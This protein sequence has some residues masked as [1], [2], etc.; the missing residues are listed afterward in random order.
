[1]DFYGPCLLRMDPVD[2][3][4]YYMTWYAFKLRKKL[5]GLATSLKKRRLLERELSFL[6]GVL[7]ENR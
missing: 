6:E 7:E 3:V 2:D 1:M 5:A 4:D